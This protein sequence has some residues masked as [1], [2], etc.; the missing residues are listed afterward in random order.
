MELICYGGIVVVSCLGWVFLEFKL[1]I[2]AA[3]AVGVVV[4][5]LYFV[6]VTRRSAQLARRLRLEEERVAVEKW[7]QRYQ[8]EILVHREECERLMKLH[9]AQ[10]AAAEIRQLEVW[11]AIDLQYHQEMNR[12]LLEKREFD[13]RLEEMRHAEQQ[14]QAERLER[15]LA[16]SKARKEL[17]DVLSRIRAKLEDFRRRIHSESALIAAAQ[18]RFDAAKSGELN[19]IRKLHQRRRELQ[20]QQFLSS[21]R[22]QSAN[23][24][25][26][27]PER[28]ATLL[29]FGIDS[30]NDVKPGLNLPGFGPVMLANLLGW[31]TE[32]ENRFR[33]NPA[34]P[35]PAADVNAVKVRFGNARQAAIGDLRKIFREFESLESEVSRSVARD[36]PV[37][38]ELGRALQQATAD[39]TLCQ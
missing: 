20:L 24:P 36:K 39:L 11:K 28:R 35:L 1:P 21:Q 10:V 32:C 3:G 9:E 18:S 31:R 13:R 22:V 23:I 34:L 19:E 33:F 15:T 16:H 14:W 12:Y 29:A 25:L 2:A 38:I 30:A 6:L 17:D 37:A 5:L 4:I 7:E 27:G 8:K 26:I